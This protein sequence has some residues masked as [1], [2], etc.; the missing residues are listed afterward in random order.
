MPD[1]PILIFK[2]YDIK[3]L[4]INWNITNYD[5]WAKPLAASATLGARLCS[6]IPVT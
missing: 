5:G 1:Q 4:I 6:D 3:T 2:I